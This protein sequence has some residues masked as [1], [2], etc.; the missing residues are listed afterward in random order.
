MTG[1]SG[2]FHWEKLLENIEKGYVIPVIGRQF[3]HAEF[4]TNTVK[5]RYPLYRYLAESLSEKTTPGKLQSFPTACRNYLSK[6]KDQA[7]LSDFLSKKLKPRDM[8][9]PMGDPLW[10]LTRVKPFKYFFTSAYDNLIVRCLRFSRKSK[11]HSFYYTPRERNDAVIKPD[12]KD[13]IKRKNENLTFQFFGNV[14]QSRFASYTDCTMME[15]IFKIHSEFD[16]TI[17]SQ[18]DILAQILFTHDLLLLGY[19]FD[20]WLFRFL[21]CMAY[22]PKYK[23][24]DSGVKWYLPCEATTFKTVSKSL[25]FLAKSKPIVFYE[26][27]SRTF[28]NELYDKISTPQKIQ[29]VEFPSTAFISFEGKDRKIARKLTNRL[30]GDGI[31][32]WLDED[33]LRGGENVADAVK[34][35]I[36]NSRVFIPLTSKNT[37]KLEAGGKLK[38]HTQE[39]QFAYELWRKKMLKIIPLILDK[40]EN[41]YD[42]FKTIAAFD[43]PGRED[44]GYEKLKNELLEIQDKLFHE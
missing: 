11:T 25:P 32:V 37:S 9:L 39:W 3:I 5:S 44:D 8:H 13:G 12:V 31:S 21:L 15:S 22:S 7:E 30:Q 27:D 24:E 41:L 36:E 20:D 38:Y 10:K 40:K 33:K 1:D 2:N 18:F 14:S 17:D 35:A 43:F 19:D 34:T 16:T 4:T 23:L 29:P 28:T 26:K 6:G 42:S